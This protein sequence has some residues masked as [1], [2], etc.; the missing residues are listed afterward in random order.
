MPVLPISYD[1]IAKIVAISDEFPLS[2][3]Q[4]L[5]L[6]VSQLNS[7]YK[8]L[9]QTNKDLPPPPSKDTHTK[10]LSQMVHKMHQAAGALM[11]AQQFDEAA[12]KYSLALGLAMARS[13]YESFQMT[14]PEVV[15][16]LIGRCDAW[17]N[18][19]KFDLA[20]QDAEV[21][22]LL[23]PQIPDN[24]LRRGIANTNLGQLEDAKVDIERGISFNGK[25]P[26]LLKM[27]SILLEIIAE[28]NGDL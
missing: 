12:H 9:I 25:H 15:V 11:K 7:L 13:K 10:Q 17:T 27:H 24:H 4:D 14:L 1:P 23:G 20:L 22:C 5:P 18:A 3:A 8:D 21:L 19:R 26:I 6:E 28:E 2:Q 16:C